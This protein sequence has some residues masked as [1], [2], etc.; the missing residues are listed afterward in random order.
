[1]VKFI[2]LKPDEPEISRKGEAAYIVN[3]HTTLIHP[4]GTEEKC[5]RLHIRLPSEPE[6]V[7]I[8]LTGE[9]F[10]ELLKIMTGEE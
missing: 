4:D 6:D 3:P 9:H 7:E 8:F 10:R 1:M 5:S 2:R